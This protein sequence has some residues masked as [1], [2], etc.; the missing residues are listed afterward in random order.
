MVTE[1]LA[2]P[3]NF[4]YL[5]KQNLSPSIHLQT[6]FNWLCHLIETLWRMRNKFIFEHIYI[7]TVGSQSQRMTSWGMGIA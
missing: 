6:I 3:G 4:I 2:A 5:A 7:Y 1:T